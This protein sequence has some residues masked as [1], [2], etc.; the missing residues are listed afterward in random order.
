MCYLRLSRTL[1]CI[2]QHHSLS[3]PERPVFADEW[4]EAGDCGI[5]KDSA[6][7]NGVEPFAWNRNLMMMYTMRNTLLSD[8]ITDSLTM[9][10][11]ASSSTL[12]TWVTARSTWLSLVC[13]SLVCVTSQT[14]AA[15]TDFPAKQLF[16][17][18]C[19]KCHSDGK[20]RVNLRLQ[21]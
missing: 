9:P 2:M 17:H 5:A 18:H 7:L 4:M 15:E 3:T 16:T 20:Q 1:D 10:A 11:W 6:K 14:M 19:E 21:V 12:Y 8:A 13:A